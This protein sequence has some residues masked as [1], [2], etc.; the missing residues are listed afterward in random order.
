MS[1]LKPHCI[2]RFWLEGLCS[3]LQG[4]ST[5]LQGLWLRSS[6]LVFQCRLKCNAYFEEPRE[7]PGRGVVRSR[8]S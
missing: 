8:R 4:L 7:G 1:K 2:R 6:H 5:A 3:G